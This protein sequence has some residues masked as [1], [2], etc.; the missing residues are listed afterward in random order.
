MEAQMARLP[1]I[2]AAATGLVVGAGA[3]A[4]AAPR[5]AAE[6]V[7]QIN[8]ILSNFAFTPQNLRLNRGQ[9]YRLHFVNQGSDAHNY[10]APEFFAA[11]RVNPADVGTVSGGKVELAKG[12]SRDVRLVPAAGS[13]N[14]ACTHLLHASFGMTGSITVN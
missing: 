12:E 8:V 2:L 6:R 11:A 10:S 3:N 13:Y 1:I 14:V 7:Q 9:A 4:L 5:K